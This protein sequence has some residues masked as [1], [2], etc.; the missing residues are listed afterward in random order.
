MTRRAFEPLSLLDEIG[1]ISELGLSTLVVENFHIFDLYRRYFRDGLVTGYLYPLESAPPSWDIIAIDLHFDEVAPL[2]AEHKPKIHH[3]EVDLGI[4]VDLH[5]H[6]T[7]ATA[8][9]RRCDFEIDVRP[10]TLPF[11][12]SFSVNHCPMRRW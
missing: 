12:I 10:K 9:F 5:Q 3:G 2:I 6:P 1:E 7:F 11:F 4:I 8:F